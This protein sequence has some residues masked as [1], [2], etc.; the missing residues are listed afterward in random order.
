MLKMNLEK[1]EI[2]HKDRDQMLSRRKARRFALQVLFCNDFLGEDINSVIPRIAETLNQEVDEF[3]LKLIN[4]TTKHI[5]KL[6]LLILNG[7]TDKDIK[8]VPKLDKALLR[9]ALCEIL[10]FS[11]IPIE[12]T[13]NEAIELS[14]EFISIKSSRFINGILDTIY[15]NLDKEKK[16]NKDVTTYLPSLNSKIQ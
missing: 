2:D 5:E 4:T 16:I 14:K 6:D 9:L 11:D 3:S 1:K 15:K 13:L 8:R 10:Y 7:L 12:V